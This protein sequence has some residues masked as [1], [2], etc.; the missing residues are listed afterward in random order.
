MHGNIDD[1]SAKQ[2]LDLCFV[3]HLDDDALHGFGVEGARVFPPIG[4]AHAPVGAFVADAAV[5]HLVENAAV[6]EPSG[7]GQTA[8]GDQASQK[9]G[10][11]EQERLGTLPSCADGRH[12]A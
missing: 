12:H 11:F 2:N 4:F 3:H 7:F 6:D 10:R 8:S 9:P 1:L 5:D